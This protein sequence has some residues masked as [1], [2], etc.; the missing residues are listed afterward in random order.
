MDNGMQ[1]TNVEKNQI[2]RNAIQTKQPKIQ[3]SHVQCNQSSV[4]TLINMD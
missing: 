4:A 1:Q 2:L 3:V